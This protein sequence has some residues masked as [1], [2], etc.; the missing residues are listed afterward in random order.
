MNWWKRV[1][2]RQPALVL[3][4]FRIDD[5][6]LR[7][8]QPILQDLGTELG[9]ELR[10]GQD[11]GDAVLV[12]ALVARSVPPQLLQSFCEERP[13]IA[14]W[15]QAA[16]SGQVRGD[17]HRESLHTEM[18]ALLQRRTAPCVTGRPQLPTGEHG[19]E[20]PR[21]YTDSGFDSG[22]DSRYPG[23]SLLDS[24]ADEGSGNFLRA[25]HRGLAA[26][27]RDALVAG[28]GERAKLVIDFATRRALLQPQALAELRL[29]HR[30]P[31]LE[32]GD[33]PAAG[34]QERA[35]ECVVWDLGWAA[36]A[37][38]LHGAPAD[39][40]HRP[41]RPLQ[42]DAVARCSASPLHRE[43]AAAVARGGVTPAQLRR[44]CRT[45][46]RELRGFLQAALFLKL[47]RYGRR[48]DWVA[49]PPPMPTTRVV[50]PS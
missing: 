16:A 32:V 9:I 42:I 24:P 39:W 20:A 18:Q 35:L 3:Q 11:G 2:E 6:A 36:G 22:L 14:L 5:L 13:L 21:D 19:V 34:L 30:L 29:G 15:R 12:D 41:L 45:S 17:I 40:L 37:L 4:G 33:L 10:L 47:L 50:S 46:L 27:T 38:P 8:L 1:G 26:P 44:Q 43:M 25:L 49:T 23:P 7:E 48:D 28:Y 31:A